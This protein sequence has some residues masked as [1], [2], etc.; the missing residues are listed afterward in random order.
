MAGDTV[1]DEGKGITW[2][3]KISLASVVSKEP[4]IGGQMV[5]RRFAGFALV[6]A[7]ATP[8]TRAFAVDARARGNGNNST[9][10][11]GRAVPGGRQLPDG[12]TPALPFHLRPADPFRERRSLISPLRSI[13][14][15]PEERPQDRGTRVTR[16]VAMVIASSRT[17]GCRGRAGAAFLRTGHL[18]L[19]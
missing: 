13:R 8:R 18:S 11:S 16:V 9:R 14:P 5:G 3:K 12:K 17:C 15:A 19:L 6:P 1:R 10:A 7:A 2:R 4:S